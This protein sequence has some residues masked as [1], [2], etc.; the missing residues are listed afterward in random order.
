MKIKETASIALFTA[1]MVIFSQISLPI[2]LSP[3]PVTLSL[4]AVF[5]TSMLLGCKSST[6]V[7]FIYVLLGIIGVPVFQGFTGGMGKV[8]GPTGGY[9]ISY[10]PASYIM[11]L[12]IF[13]SKVSKPLQT[14]LVMLTGLLICYTFGTAWLMILTKMDVVKALYVAVLPFVPLD[15]LKIIAASI[16]SH[17][18]KKRLKKAGK[19][20]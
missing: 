2:P 15:I 14:A 16:L 13:K 4:F 8:F 12:I 19:S 6:A 20:L 9:I 7:Q 17:A 18:I 1:V 5:L 3:V 10:I 11:G